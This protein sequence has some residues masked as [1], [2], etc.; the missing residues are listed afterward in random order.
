VSSSGTTVTYIPT[1]TFID[2]GHCLYT[3]TNSQGASTAAAITVMIC[4]CI[5][6]NATGGTLL[7][8]V[9]YYQPKR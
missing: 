5:Q 6:I 9:A 3:I 7:A 8:P 4:A 2:T 1:P